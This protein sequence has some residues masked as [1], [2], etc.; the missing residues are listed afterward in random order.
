[1]TTLLGGPARPVPALKDRVSQRVTAARD[2]LVSL[3]HAIHENPEPAC[4]ET[5][6]AGW[7]TEVVRPDRVWQWS[8]EASVAEAGGG[9]WGMKTEPH[10][11]RPH[12]KKSPREALRDGPQLLSS[13]RSRRESRQSQWRFSPEAL[14]AS[15]S[16]MVKPWTVPG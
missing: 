5:R 14:K 1:M 3:S 9:G 13:L 11:G 10:S 2:R 6:A 8:C 7:V 12:R 15:V 16:D 4:E